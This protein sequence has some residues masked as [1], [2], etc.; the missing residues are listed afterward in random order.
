MY[1]HTIDFLL[2]APVKAAFREKA[3]DS[4]KASSRF[5]YPYTDKKAIRELF[6]TTFLSLAVTSQIST[7]CLR[8]C[9]SRQYE[10][11]AGV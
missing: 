1:T 7:L 4:M 11:I 9:P 3:A 2:E 10:V 5:H 6:F 8:F